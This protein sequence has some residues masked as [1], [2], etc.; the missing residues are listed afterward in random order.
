MSIS[1][2]L[3]IEQIV[4][5]ILAIGKIAPMD[6]QLLSLALSNPLTEREN[7]LVAHLHRAL[8]LGKVVVV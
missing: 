4:H 3:T 6:R 1:Q 2:P 8:R 5:Q 7:Q